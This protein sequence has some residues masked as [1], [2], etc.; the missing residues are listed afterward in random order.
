M[1][2]KEFLLLMTFFIGLSCTKDPC[3][4]TICLNDGFCIDGSCYCQPWYTGS[5]CENEQREQFY[6]QYSGLLQILD[7]NENV[8]ATQSISMTFSPG[9]AINLLTSSWGTQIELTSS[10]FSEFRF[11]PWYVSGANWSGSGYFS[12]DGN[13]VNCV[14]L[15]N[16]PGDLPFMWKFIANR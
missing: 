8:L 1:K 14:G 9:G 2:F 3:A 11:M 6:G 7:Q 5:N 13:T 12:N 10:G 4:E 15:V 16:E